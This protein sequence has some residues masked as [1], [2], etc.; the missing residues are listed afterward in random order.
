MEIGG[1]YGFY[2]E[3]DEQ[4]V[5]GRG[6]RDRLSAIEKAD[7]Y[8]LYEERVQELKV[9]Q[10]SDEPLTPEINEALLVEIKSLQEDKVIIDGVATQLQRW[11]DANLRAATS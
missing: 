10:S 5:I 3:K 2:D 11:Q 9:K 4:R 8:G 7:L 1:Q 6:E